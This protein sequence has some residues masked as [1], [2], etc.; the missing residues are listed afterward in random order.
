MALLALFVVIAF[1]LCP[2]PIS[3]TEHRIKA[4]T[5]RGFWSS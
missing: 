3:L 2:I 1:V 5:W 4:G